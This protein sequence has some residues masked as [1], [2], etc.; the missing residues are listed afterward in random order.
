MPTWD[1]GNKIEN[2]NVI[3][4]TPASAWMIADA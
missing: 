3:E 1:I 2:R 4:I